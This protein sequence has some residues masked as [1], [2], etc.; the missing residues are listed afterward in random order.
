MD[1]QNHLT[2]D[3]LELVRS[4]VRYAAVKSAE[5]PVTSLSTMTTVPLRRPAKSLTQSVSAVVMRNGTIQ[6]PVR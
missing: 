4:A 2:Q 5:I 1:L 6:I 3:E